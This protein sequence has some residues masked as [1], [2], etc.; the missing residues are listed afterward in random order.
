[1]WNV[2]RISNESVLHSVYF[3]FS[4]QSWDGLITT[5]YD[6]TIESCVVRETSKLN[7]QGKYFSLGKLC[8]RKRKY[9]K[10]KKRMR[11]SREAEMEENS[12][13]TISNIKLYNLVR[14]SLKS[15]ASRLL[16]C[17][18]KNS[19]PSRFQDQ[20]FTDAIDIFMDERVNLP[21]EILC[22]I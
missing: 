4:I 15:N 2:S 11:A 8:E 21:N 22:N 20:L 7:R 6:D 16:V 5:L 19:G 18:L 9:L 17:T 3:P 10:E 13:T 14:D 12:S 1:M